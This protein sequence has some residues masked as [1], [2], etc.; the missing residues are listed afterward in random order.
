MRTLETRLI[1][2]IYIYFR[3][4]NCVPCYV[5]KGHGRRLHDHEKDGEEHKN[6]HFANIL[7]KA[8]RLGLVVPK[9]ILFSGLD[10][11]TAFY[12][13]TTWIKA[14]GR[15]ANRPLVNLTD[16]GEGS[17]GYRHTDTAK[18]KN[19]KASLG[20]TYALG[21]K[22]TKDTL[23]IL[24]EKSKGHKYTPPKT[25]EAL[26]R[27]KARQSAASLKMWEDEN[28]RLEMSKIH[29][30]LWN[31]PKHREKVLHAHQKSFETP[32]RKEAMSATAVLVWAARTPERM[33][34]ISAKRRKD[35]AKRWADPAQRKVISDKAKKRWSDP[36]FIQKCRDA[37]AVRWANMSEAKKAALLESLSLGQK[38]R[39]A[40][41]VTE[42]S[43]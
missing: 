28:F 9:V 26:K 19:R 37:Q 38:R 14:I 41:E 1:F 25:P 5:G 16:G 15:G 27:K 2:Y 12:Y 10:E 20:N 31:D 35:A 42:A 7:K 17:T 36:I 32:G 29:K 34:E 22:H 4:W 21:Y 13:E 8:K 3:P 33:K 30:E 11:E 39:R 43:L 24:S 23:K 18:E 40:R 6:K